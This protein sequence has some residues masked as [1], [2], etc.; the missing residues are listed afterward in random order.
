MTREQIQEKL[1]TLFAGE[2]GLARES[3]NLAA[4]IAGYGLDSVAVASVLGDVET[5]SGKRI[6]PGLMWKQPS[7]AAI[8][9]HLADTPAQ[10]DDALTKATPLPGLAELESRFEA[11]ADAQVADPFFRT[12]E[13]LG[14]DTIGATDGPL[15]NFASYNY[16]G[17]AGDPKVRQAAREAIDRYGTSVSASR[18]SAGE[19]PLHR[20][21]ERALARLSE[22]QDAL[23]F[24][25]GY[26]TNV[27]VI[28]HLYSGADLIAYDSSMHNS[29]VTG[30][31][32]S[33]ARCLA[34]PH[35]DTQALDEL[36]TR[37]RAAHRRVLVLAEGVY[38]TNGDIPDLGELVRVKKK[39]AAWLMIDEAHSI[40]VLGPRG[41]GL[42]DH[43]G[44]KEHQIDIV[45]GTLSKALASCGG[46]VAGSADLIRYLRYTCPGFIFSAGISPPNAAAALKAAEILEAEPGRAAGLRHNAQTL[47]RL[48]RARGLD[49][50]SSQGSGVVPIMVGDDLRAMRLSNELFSKGVNVQPLV[51]PAVEADGAR[52][53]FFLSSL[54]THEQ[55]ETAMDLTAALLPSVALSNDRRAAR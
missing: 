41:R 20:D 50:G 30:A 46:Y 26:A 11:L 42:A 10:S 3:L 6:D 7:I 5:W 35:N 23:V 48:A 37:E 16:L 2:T 22:T 29:A 12:F 31:R 38:S 53:R 47:I 25:G 8:V 45:M 15:I 24:V 18:L 28:G 4:P 52:L 14:A 44:M 1:I 34:F 32:L 13:G 55:I 17:L 49:T 43:W 51:T 27:S 9:D 40:G 39:H 19:R 21:L 36:L 33:G 54:H